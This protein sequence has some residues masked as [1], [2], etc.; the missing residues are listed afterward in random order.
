MRYILEVRHRSAVRR[1]RGTETTQCSRT[2]FSHGRTVADRWIVEQDKLT[3]GQ[4]RTITEI[5]SD[6]KRMVANAKFY[7]DDKSIIYG[8]AERIRKL[9]SNFMLR[10]NPAYKN[11][12]YV[13]FPTPIPG[14]DGV[15]GTIV[16]P[17]SRDM[18]EKPKK[19]TIS[20]KAARDRTSSV[21]PNAMQVD[22]DAGSGDFTGK[23]FQQAQEQLMEEMIKFTDEE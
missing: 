18:S 4:Y 12:D 21:D 3:Q 11:P 15:N 16:H 2:A 13:A 5:E 17:P 7:N 8:D 10:N 19:P 20:L 22:G 6:V 9:L 1:K 14:E 23:T